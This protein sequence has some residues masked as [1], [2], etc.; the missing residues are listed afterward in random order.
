MRV[1]PAAV[2]RALRWPMKYFRRDMLALLL[3]LM[4]AQ[5]MPVS[6]KEFL[7]ELRAT[8]KGGRWAGPVIKARSLAAAKVLMR[9]SPYKVIGELVAT[10]AVPNGDVTRFVVPPNGR[11]TVQ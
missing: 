10:I 8:Y 5:T 3:E 1:T 2:K 4:E 11:I 7:T 6:E 9:D